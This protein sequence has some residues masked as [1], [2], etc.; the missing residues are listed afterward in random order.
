MLGMPEGPMQFEEDLAQ[1]RHDISLIQNDTFWMSQLGTVVFNIMN[2]LKTIRRLME[3][4]LGETTRE[5][6]LKDVEEDREEL[7]KFEEE[8]KKRMRRG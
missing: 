8:N 2:E 5:D 7:R 3:I 6:V 1:I 4:Q